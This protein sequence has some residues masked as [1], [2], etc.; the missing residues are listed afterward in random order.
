MN[1]IDISNQ[2][3]NKGVSDCI[4]E[5]EKQKDALN[6]RIKE[7]QQAGIDSSD[8]VSKMYMLNELIQI[9]KNLKEGK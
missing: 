4:K 2:G 7:K 9:L 8:Y 6:K 3:Y 5:L 1:V